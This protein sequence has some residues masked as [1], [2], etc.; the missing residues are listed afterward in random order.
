MN[1]DTKSPTFSRE[2]ELIGKLFLASDLFSL[3]LKIAYFLST[4]HL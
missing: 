4:P 3:L 2:D 1:N